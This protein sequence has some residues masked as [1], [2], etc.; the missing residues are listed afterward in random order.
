MKNTTIIR[1]RTGV[2]NLLFCNFKQ[3][4][5]ALVPVTGAFLLIYNNCRPVRV[6]QGKGAQA[7][8]P[9]EPSKW[10]KCLGTG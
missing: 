7:V 3:R 8:A 9:E 4:I 2:V 5:K 10:K 6:Q 1:F